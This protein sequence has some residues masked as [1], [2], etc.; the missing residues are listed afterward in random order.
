M[1]AST[2]RVALA[3][4]EP[5]N[6]PP[7]KRIAA[8]DIDGDTP[9]PT[10]DYNLQD[11]LRQVEQ[12]VKEKAELVVFPEYFLQGIANEGRQYLTIASDHLIT[13]LSSLAAHHSICIAGT[14]VHGVLPAGSAPPPI[15]NPFAHLPLS[16]TQRV[17]DREGEKV[18]YQ[19]WARY[20]E[21]YSEAKAED[22]PELKNT[23]FFINEKGELIGEYIKKNL[24]HPEREYLT[25]GD[26]DHAVFETKWGKV[27]MLICWD[28]SHPAATH[29]IA[30]L[31]ADIIICPTYWLS[32][33]S[34][35]MLSNHPHEARYEF[36]VV[37]SLCFAR[38]FEAELV[39]IMCNAGGNASEGF[40]GGSAVW[41]PLQGRVG[42]F[43][44]ETTGV[45]VIDVDIKVLK[46]ARD[47]YKIREDWARVN[48]S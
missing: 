13:H 27:G 32:T 2:L 47:T 25:A 20:L 35:P 22:E 48:A 45:K 34:E 1:S 3:Q 5:R 14:V 23:A 10:I 46:D 18:Q 6:A 12:A 17:S 28:M 7:G 41:A 9:F 16:S 38:S 36:S 30:D 26:E 24:W 39:W 42:G 21:S 40:M 19:E 8:K 11:A 29:T 37:S 15:S 33:D 4:T 43:D 31:G 44:D